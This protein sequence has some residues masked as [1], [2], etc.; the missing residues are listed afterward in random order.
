MATFTVTSTHT[1]TYTVEA[2]TPEE[3]EQIGDTLPDN[4]MAYWT[5]CEEVSVQED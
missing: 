3:A 2:E 1:F 5:S 4:P